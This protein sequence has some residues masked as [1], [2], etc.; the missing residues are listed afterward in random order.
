MFSRLSTASTFQ[1]GPWEGNRAVAGASG[2]V[3]VQGMGKEGTVVSAAA[4]AASVWEAS[5]PSQRFGKCG[6]PD[7][8]TVLD[9]KGGHPDATTVIGDYSLGSKS[10]KA[11]CG[12]WPQG[13]QACEFSS[14]K[15]VDVCGGGGDDG[16]SLSAKS[17]R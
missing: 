3:E 9:G 8:A 6:K 10:A 16:R 14:R 12:S 13:P 2:R 11:A 7:V 5:S 15:R 1:N 17:W 4:A